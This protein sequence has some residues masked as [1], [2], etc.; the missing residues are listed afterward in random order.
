MLL[1]EKG[2]ARMTN[3]QENEFTRSES[4]RKIQ[5][6][7]AEGKGEEKRGKM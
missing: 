6:H 7:F 1:R 4:E 3:G 2:R 5:I